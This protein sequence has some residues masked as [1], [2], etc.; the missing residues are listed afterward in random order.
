[1]ICSLIHGAVGAAGSILLLLEATQLQ[2]HALHCYECRRAGAEKWAAIAGNILL[3]SNPEQPH[4]FSA[5]I[6][7]FGMCRI[8]DMVAQESLQ[9]TYS[10]MAPEV[11]QGQEFS[12][13]GFL[14][15]PGLMHLHATNNPMPL[16]C[17]TPLC[18]LADS[19]QYMHSPRHM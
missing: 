17:M 4:G 15:P 9:G 14:L 12:A 6:S 2:Q 16:S 5:K 18:L 1:M 8:K 19:L 11:I 3:C 13:V 10:H 7:D